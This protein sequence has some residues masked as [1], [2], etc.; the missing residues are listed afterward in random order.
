MDLSHPLAEVIGN[1]ADRIQLGVT[2]LATGVEMG[3]LGDRAT[4]QYTDAK[5]C[6]SLAIMKDFLR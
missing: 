4:P 3:E 5:L 6:V 2:R 1:V